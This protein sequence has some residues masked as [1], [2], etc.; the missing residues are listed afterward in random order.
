MVPQINLS[1]LRCSAIAI[2]FAASVLSAQ[3]PKENLQREVGTN[4]IAGSVTGAA[5]KVTTIAALKAVSVARMATAQQVEVA[6]YLAAGDGG[7]GIFQYNSTSVADDD[8]GTII[9]PNSGSGRWI[10]VFIGPVQA[11]WFNLAADGAT[12]DRTKLLAAIAASKAAPARALELY[13][14][15]FYST[16]TLDVSGI[17]IV[18]RGATLKGDGTSNLL[19]AKGSVG[20]YQNLGSNATIGATSIS[21]A[22]LAAI[23]VAGDLVK[24]ISSAAF[25]ASEPTRVQGE[26]QFVKSTATPV[27]TLAGALFD[28]Y[29][30]A[31]T[32]RAAKVTPTTFYAEDLIIQQTASVTAKG[33]EIQ[34]AVNPR[35]KNVRFV[36]CSYTGLFVSDCWGAD[37]DF[38]A[39][40]CFDAATGVSYG[41]MI[42]N[43]SMFARVRGWG[44]NCRHVVAVGGNADGGVVWECLIDGVVG[45]GAASASAAVFDAHSGA[46]SVTYRNCVANGPSTEA[47]FSLQARINRVEN[48]KALGNDSGINIASSVATMTLIIDGLRCD[49]LTTG[50]GIIGLGQVLN[51]HVS[52]LTG[53]YSRT[54]IW[55]QSGFDVLGNWSFDGIQNEETG[56]LI[57]TQSS[58]GTVPKTLAISNSLGIGDTTKNG[59]TIGSTEI[60]N[61]VLTNVHVKDCDT[62]FRSSVALISLA[63]LNCSARNPIGS[64]VITLT[65]CTLVSVVNLAILNPG[66]GTTYVVNSN[67]NAANVSLTGVFAEG[68]TLTSLARTAGGNLAVF[69]CQTNVA[70]AA[71]LDSGAAVI[72]G[73][74]INDPRAFIGTATPE[75][76]VTA[77]VGATFQRSNG[78]ANTSNYFKESGTG[79]TGWVGK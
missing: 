32:A 62:L 5:W 30:T 14:A 8:G 10:R 69:G 1:G 61:F 45:T 72:I 11:K 17:T 6:G 40:D 65:G 67:T 56:Q 19:E 50:A 55:L 78:G 41:C 31:N 42:G 66:V 4:A 25:E 59:I 22:G 16:G 28:S 60:E 71:G 33:M 29:T 70:M 58:L 2:L 48:C 37:I 73:G 3:T 20:T 13:L 27:V 26:M 35:L 12:N 51:L 79:N 64:G 75:G 54:A 36:N 74:T 76:T 38:A 68:A 34:Y 52:R 23:V 21:S 24:I 44:Q 18:G 77:N 53:N 9:A 7:G 57:E 15:T 46:G 43:A 49:R 39:L 63:A 47:G